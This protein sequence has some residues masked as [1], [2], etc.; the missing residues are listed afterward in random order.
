ME[1]LKKIGI[2]ILWTLAA[3]LGYL[4]FVVI[5]HLGFWALLITI[6]FATCLAAQFIPNQEK[7]D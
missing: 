5:I 4:A 7:E 1:M 6:V 3:V 2:A